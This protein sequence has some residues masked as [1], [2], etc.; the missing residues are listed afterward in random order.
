MNIEFS[1]VTR[2]VL[3]IT[4]IAFTPTALAAS[5]GKES[6]GKTIIAKG[7]VYSVGVDSKKT[8]HL[9]RRAPI[10]KGDVITTLDDSKAQ[11]RM[12]DG[13]MI[14]LKAHSELHIERHDEYSGVISMT[15]AKG[16]LRTVTGSIETIYGNYQLKTPVGNVISTGGHYEVDIINED[17]YLSVWTGTLDFTI[18]VGDTGDNVR[19]GEGQ[20]HSHAKINPKGQLTLLNKGR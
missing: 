5:T 13:T 16:R 19:L 11:L 14:A 6:I 9:R 15:L 4:L 2:L 3:L 18:T 8:N 10:L 7:Q 17:V 20:G 1:L 12:T